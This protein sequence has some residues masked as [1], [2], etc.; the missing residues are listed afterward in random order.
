MPRLLQVCT[1][2]V[3]FLANS[4]Q[5]MYCFTLCLALVPCF[6]FCLYF[7]R[8]DE[9]KLSYMYQHMMSSSNGNIFH[10]TG[11]LW[12]ES[13]GHRRIPLKSQCHRVWCF[14]WSAL[15]Q[16]VEHSMETPVIW[17]TIAP[18]MTSLWWYPC[19]NM[20][21]ER[22]LIPHSKFSCLYEFCLT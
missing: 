13:T 21:D 6:K 12:G 17:N 16:T 11:P 5:I 22:N 14:L 2:I 1:S 19:R 7:V 15:E 10:V 3:Y 8:N 20:S 9:M 4:L 18:I